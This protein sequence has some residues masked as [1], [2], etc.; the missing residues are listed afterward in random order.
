VKRKPLPKKSNLLLVSQAEAFFF[1]MI[2]AAL[3]KRKVK[4]QP[5]TEYY[6]VKL[7]GQ[8]M[9]TERLFTSNR[10]GEFKDEPIAFLMKDAV[11]TPDPNHRATL[12][13]YIG[14]VALYRSGFFQEALYKRNVDLGYYIQMGGGA[15]Q[16]ASSLEQKDSLKKVFSELASSFGR[17]VDVLAEVSD[18]TTPK[19]PEAIL[20]NLEQFEKTGSERA[21]KRLEARG[22]KV[23]SRQKK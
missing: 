12:F 20:Q 16:N 19:N 4:P 9:Q 7:L 3:E 8:F 18:Q 17:F 13:R 1:E 15:Y 22:I 2:Q 23:Q 6:L 10:E 5:E 11:D 14:D 21:R